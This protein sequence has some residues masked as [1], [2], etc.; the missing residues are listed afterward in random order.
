MNKAGIITLI[1]I[2]ALGKV[3][4]Q[5][6]RKADAAATKI[7]WNG[8]KVLG[9]HTG[10]ISLKEGWLTT[11]KNAITGGEFVVDM[12]TIADTDIKDEQ[13]R[14]KLEG[15]LKSDD[16][17]GVQKYP[18]SS[19]IITSGGKFDKGSATI[20]GNLTIKEKTNPVEFTV[21]ET[22]SGEAATYSAVIKI[23]RTLYD[24]KY[25]SGKF[26]SDL[27]DKAIY[28]EFTLNVTL[29]VKK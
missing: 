28:D 14:G 22:L 16:F 5:Q 9:E 1:V 11:D 19:L 4:A 25:G 18:L 3:S 20:K 2:L 7:E 23:D 27:G 24:I 10:T 6:T 8:K 12:T 13:T 29:V 17:F 15:H 21:T 26:F